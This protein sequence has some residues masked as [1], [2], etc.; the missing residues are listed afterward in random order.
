MAIDLDV[1]AQELP[2]LE[3]DRRS[4]LFGE[5]D[6]DRVFGLAHYID[7]LDGAGHEGRFAGKRNHGP[8]GALRSFDEG[9][10]RFPKDQTTAEH[11]D[12]TVRGPH[13]LGESP[14]EQDEWVDF[15]EGCGGWELFDQRR[16]RLSTRPIEKH[17]R[18]E[19]GLIEE[20]SA[21]AW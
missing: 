12:V 2:G 11:G 21:E 14:R 1:D 19:T 17:P 15:L 10:R 13:P 18:I 5:V 6:R 3:L 20:R 9:R 4:I 16:R 8:G 7:D